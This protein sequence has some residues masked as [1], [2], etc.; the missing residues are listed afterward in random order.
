MK[1]RPAF[2]RAAFALSLFAPLAVAAAN[3]PHDGSDLPVDPAVRWGRLDNGLRY[4][5]LANK[6][7]KGRASLRLTVAAG[8]LHETEEQRGLAHFLEHMAFNGST[9]FPPGTLVEYFQRLGMSFGADTN[10]STGFDRTIYLLELPDTHDATV[11][12]G[13][14]LF[15]DYAGGLLLL[16]EEIDRE[17]GI[18]L[19]EKRARDSVEFRQFV[20]EFEFLLPESRFIHRIPIGTAEVI[21][22]APREQFADFYDAWYRPELMTVVA[23]GDFDPAAIEAHLKAALSGVTS[24]GPARPVPSFGRVNQV[25]GVVARLLPEPEAAAV[26]VAI[27]TITPYAWEADTAANRLKYLPRNLALQMLN[28][29][30]SVLAKKE[31][32]PFLGGGVGVTEQFNFFR[33]SSV[34]LTCKPGQ[35]AAALAVGEQE[36]RRALQYGF[37]PAELKEAVAGLRNQLEQAVQT[38]AT[39]RS[40]SLAAALVD[41]FL[42]RNVFT[43]PATELALYAPA[44]DQVSVADCLAALRHY[45]DEQTG[46]RLWV[47]GNLT[48]DN[49]EATIIAAYQA[50]RAV[51]VNPPEKLEEAA[52]AYTDFGPAGTVVQTDQVADLGVTLVRFA[53]GVR[54]NLKPTDF[55][56]GRIRLN[57]RVGGGRLTEPEAKTGLAFFAGNTFTLGG[58]GRHSID[59]LQRVLAGKTLGNQFRIGNDSF[60]FAGTTNRQDF[61]LQVQ[62]LCAGLTDPGF[63]PEALRQFEK[64]VE[65]FYTRLGNTVEG[66]LQTEV[67]RLLADGDPRFGVP[68]KERVTAYTLADAKAWLTAEFARAPVEIAV[69]GDFDP[70]DV[71]TAVAATF[72]ALPERA[73]KPGY[74]AQRQARFPTTPLTRQYT[75][76]TEIPKGLVQLFWPATDNRDVKL[77]RRLNMLSS[78]FEDR[79]RIKLREE[80]GG[81]YSP[82]A[83][84]SLSDTYRG[85]GFLTANA[86]VAPAEARQIADA[87]RAIAADLH[88]GVVTDDELIRAREPILTSIRQ[89]QRTNPYWLGNVLAAAQEEPQRLEWSRT[90][91]SDIESITATELTE[92]AHRY[93]DPAKVSEF[94]SVPLEKP[95]APEAR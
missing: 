47:T 92:L 79:L 20:G 32:A 34:E 56:A 65:V 12:K 63:R 38:A 76:P 18:I 66:P 3:F 42:D 71:I 48:L 39:R 59:D 86:S 5:I 93:F 33:N 25:E 60:D 87:I 67:P 57:V 36:L 10:A 77:A 83:G 74:E 68:P 78:V 50:S 85:Y 2:L 95:A 4:A 89:S 1:I 30:F 45:W 23:V 55:E 58:L 73:A 88:T 81:T 13:L 24:R 62:L 80:M 72:G 6:E 90:R 46:R 11:E 40:P 61:L 53:N 84:S 54:L 44:L 35:W 51:A 75:V 27:Q 43:H 9:H 22:G 26:N 7:P 49:P 37:Q 16:P 82:N 17:R 8:S 41:D 91:I 31:G 15:A 29:R 19:S 70:A 64:G 52:F 21:Q 69:V 28:R 14:N 94:I